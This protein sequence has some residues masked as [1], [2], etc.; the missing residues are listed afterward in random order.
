M[1]LLYCISVE[2]AVS[3]AILAAAGP[4]ILDECKRFGKYMQFMQ[5]EKW[6]NL[7]PHTY[8]RLIWVNL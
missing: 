3:K 1:A 7:D 8:S 2:G 6:H 4:G 5:I